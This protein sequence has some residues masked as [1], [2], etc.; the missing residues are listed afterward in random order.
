MR[1]VDLIKVLQIRAHYVQGTCTIQTNF[2]HILI[3]NSTH[4]QILAYYSNFCE[5][6]PI[7]S[8]QSESFTHFFSCCLCFMHDDNFIQGVHKVPV[9]FKKFIILF[10][11]AIKIICKKN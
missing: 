3:E 9:H 10:V 4:K 1:G 11:S 7:V 2:L 6:Y 8:L 5:E